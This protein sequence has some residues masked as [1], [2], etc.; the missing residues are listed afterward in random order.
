MHSEGEIT[1]PARAPSARLIAFYLPQYHPI[2][3]NDGWWGKGFTEWT[4]VAKARPL[5][6]G[7]YQPHVPADLGFYDLRVA[8]TRAAQAEL[9]QEHGIEGFCYWHYWFGG[10]QLLHRP[11]EEVLRSGEPRYPFCLAWANQSWTG[12]WHGAPNRMLIEQTYPGDADHRAHFYSL[13]DAFGD[14]RYLQVDGKPI[15]VIYNPH[16]LP[17]AARFTDLWRELALKAG[18]KG[19]YFIAIAGPGWD[20]GAHGFDATLMDN[21]N[22]AFEG[23][24]HFWKSRLD[25]VSKKLTGMG[26][27]ELKRKARARPATYEYREF[28]SHALPELST[29]YD[30]YPCVIPNWDNTPRSSLRAIVIQNSTPQ[31]YRTHLRR[32][33]DQVTGRDRD[34]RLVFVKAWNEWAEG[35]YLEPDLQFGRA[36][37]EATRD[38]VCARG[39]GAG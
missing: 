11:F 1:L 33:I 3:E 14:S 38:E 29:L 36:Y 32:A 7:H 21:P 5:F 2:P 12:I 10:R 28:M 4:N 26:F 30:N 8:E 9:A 19:L 22:V 16:S 20:P 13:A 24:G 31:L 17:E 37:L 18:L 39:S 34:R 15:F 27:K 6:P 25:G 35:N 23:L